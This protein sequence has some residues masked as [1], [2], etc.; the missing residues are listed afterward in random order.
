M[1]ACELALNCAA[2]VVDRGGPG[3]VRGHLQAIFMVGC[4][5]GVRTPGPVAATADL[6]DRRYTSTRLIPRSA[7]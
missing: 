4:G 6:R 7:L 3:L 1:Q 5:N 2:R